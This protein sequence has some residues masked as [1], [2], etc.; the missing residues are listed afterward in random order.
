MND[1]KKL[2]TL[3]SILFAISCLNGM[4]RDIS[5]EKSIFQYTWLYPI[6]NP[7]AGASSVVQTIN[8]INHI[9]NKAHFQKFRHNLRRKKEANRQKAAKIFSEFPNEICEKFMLQIIRNSQKNTLKAVLTE[10]L[11]FARTN[12]KHWH[13][14]NKDKGFQ[15]EIYHTLREKFKNISTQENYIENISL[16]A[17]TLSNSSI[18]AKLEKLIKKKWNNKNEALFYG[19]KKEFLNLV[20]FLIKNGANVNTRDKKRRTILHKAYNTNNKNTKL[21]KFLIGE[22]TDVNA[23]D[24]DGCTPLHN[25]I[26]I[27]NLEAAEFLINKGAHVDAMD[28]RGDTPLHRVAWENHLKAAKFLIK[29]DVNINVR[30]RCGWTPLHSAVWS[31]HLKVAELLINK[32]ADVNATDHRGNT[33][34]HRAMWENNLEAAMLLIQNGANINAIDKDGW[35]PLHIIL[36]YQPT[37]IRIVKFLVKNGANINATNQEGNTPLYI[38]L[39]YQPANTKIAKFLIKNGAH[40]NIYNKNGRSPLSLML[41]Y[42]LFKTYTMIDRIFNYIVV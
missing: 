1:T 31:D 20:K 11:A 9:N 26:R 5:P 38:V 17:L 13:I 3:V 4:E 42:C 29:Q 14:L 32:G 37:G 7:V 23:I 40:I 34:L 2:G 33:P 12:K 24:K 22:N 10:V 21:I 25:A 28:H 6:F 8:A 19:I 15:N 41:T 16:I 39:Y 36:Y 27:D 18:P 30:D 35:T